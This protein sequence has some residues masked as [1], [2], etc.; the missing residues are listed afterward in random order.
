MRRRLAQALLVAL[1]AACGPA[2]EPDLIDL[3]RAPACHIAG[4]QALLRGQ[5]SGPLRILPQRDE[6]PIECFLRLPAKDSVLHFRLPDSAPSGAV[7]VEVATDEAERRLALQPTSHGAYRARLEG[8]DGQVV[9]LRLDAG[10]ATDWIQPRVEGIG[11]ALPPP[12]ALPEPRPGGERPNVLLFVVD[13]LR[14]D[15]LSVYGYA[16]DTSPRLAELARRATVFDNAYA[17]GPNTRNSIPSLL[18]SIPA[19]EVHGQL[20]LAATGVRTVL[21]QVF[22]RAGYRTG[23]FQA[24]L[25]LRPVLGFGRGFDTY[26]VLGSRGNTARAEALRVRALEWLDS[27]SGPFFLFIQSFDVHDPYEPPAPFA[28]RFGE[29]PVL[30][31]SRPPELGLFPFTQAWEDLYERVLPDLK[32]QFYDDAVAYTDHEIG[33]LLDGLRE[34]GLL[35]STL[36][37]VTAD[38]GEALGEGNRW[39]HG[40]SLHEEQVRVPLIVARPGQQQAVRSGEV[41][42][43][44]DLAPTL[45]ELAGLEP[46]AQFRGRSLVQ[47]RPARAP[48][49]IVGSLADRGW[50]VRKGDWKLVATRETAWLHHLPADPEESVDRGDEFP[51]RKGYLTALLRARSR[52][53]RESGFE[54]LPFDAGLSEEDRKQL[55]EDLRALGYAE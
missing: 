12:L 35:D 32:P 4:E 39:L 8:F 30:P 19:N 9:R 36:V 45:L 5:Q 14:A 46:P 6:R 15:R 34:R 51:V 2:R 31:R 41:V 42:S 54:P 38:H 47:S 40:I 25:W 7:R 50:F 20:R 33:L 22:R 29:A 13:A 16:R 44:L 49:A 3:T 24:N 28:G 17:T 11:A 26:E 43:L 27:G 10:G 37:L 18:S 48:R 1:A 52:A 21:A 53:F 55:H 23:A